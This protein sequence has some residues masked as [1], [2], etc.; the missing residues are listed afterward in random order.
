MFK[1][2][3]T[4]TTINNL[5]FCPGFAFIQAKYNEIAIK[6]NKIFQTT[7]KIQFGGVIAGFL[8]MLLYYIAIRKGELSLIMPLAFTSPFWG[9]L[10]AL[11]WKVETLTNQRLIGMVLILY[12][13]A[14]TASPDFKN[15]IYQSKSLISFT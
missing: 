2:K 6:K 3:L 13:I 9:T 8:G 1:I 4:P 10:L 11:L 14:Y 5:L 12:G 7:G 15:P